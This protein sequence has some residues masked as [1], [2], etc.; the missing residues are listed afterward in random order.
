MT[1]MTDVS[2]EPLGQPVRVSDLGDLLAGLPVL[3]GFRPTDSL[4]AICLE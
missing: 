4:V 3:F 1:G 2:Q